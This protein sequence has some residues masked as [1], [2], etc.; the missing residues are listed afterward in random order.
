MIIIYVGNNYDEYK[1]AVN[2]TDNTCSTL[3]PVVFRLV[4]MTTDFREVH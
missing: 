4:G 3:L 1:I 2:Y